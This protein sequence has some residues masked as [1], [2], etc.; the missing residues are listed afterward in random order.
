M[1][2]HGLA[3]AERAGDE[4]GAAFGDRVE[5]VEHTDT[6]LHNPLGTRFL[7]ISLHSHLHGP[8]LDHGDLHIL[9]VFGGEDRNHGVNV[10]LSGFLYALD[11]VFSLEGEG[12]H[13]FVGQPAF[14]HFAQPTCGLHL[15]AHLCL[16]SEIPEFVVVQRSG[17]LASLEEDVLHGG[18]V[19]L[20]SIVGTGQKTGAELDLEHLA[21]ELHG[22]SAPEAAGALKHLHGRFVAA[23]LDDFGKEL[24][25]LEVD[26][27]EFVFRHRTVHLHSHQVG[28]NARY[29]T[30]CTHYLLYFYCF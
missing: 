8:F 20:Q 17:V 19:V 15:V 7:F 13:N 25:A 5:G 10:I 1:L 28:H 9:A 3:A 26:V 11:G 14:L 24:R 22:I 21:E 29:F 16:G 2:K 4:S 30:C 27:A 6:S 18:E 12:D 23:D